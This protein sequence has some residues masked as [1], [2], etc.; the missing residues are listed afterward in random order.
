MSG[1]YN[2]AGEPIG[3]LEWAEAHETDRRVAE[4]TVGKLWVST[5]W[6]GLDHA[7]LDGPPL[8]FETM[9][10]KGSAAEVE[11]WTEEYCERYSTEAAALAGHEVA[12]A[13]AKEH[14][15]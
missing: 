8:I 14:Q 4:T 7:F 9:V 2:R 5:V 11:D 12:V 3:M 1:Y 10:F 15:P 13:W 6:L